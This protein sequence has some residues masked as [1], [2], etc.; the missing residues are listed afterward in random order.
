MSE[1]DAYLAHYGVK[2]MKWGRRKNDDG[3]GREPRTSEEKKAIAK[4]VA[5]ASG[6][7]LAAAGAAYAIHTLNKNGNLKVSDLKVDPSV[8]KKTETQITEPTTHIL[9]SKGGKNGLTFYKDGNLKDPLLE[10]NKGFPND[11][12]E[13][14]AK[15]GN[16][17]IAA[18]LPDPEGRKDRAGRPISH[19]IIIPKGMTDGINDLKDVA[20]KI[21]PIVKED[22]D[23]DAPMKTMR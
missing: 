10:F 6:T 1:L 14:F 21:W 5:I 11:G 8:K 7:L 12:W 15:Y 3:S 17:K 2:G 20:E 9:F 4:K 13:P 16:G 23:Y 18:T 22:Y 19:Q